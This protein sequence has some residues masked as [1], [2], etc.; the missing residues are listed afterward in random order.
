MVSGFV[1]QELCSYTKY[2]VQK[3]RDFFFFFHLLGIFNM[4][5]RYQIRV[6]VI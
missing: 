4:L 5:I 2:A 1:M 6:L 3:G